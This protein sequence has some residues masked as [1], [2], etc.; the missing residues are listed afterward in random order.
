MNN[1]L[2]T[3]TLASGEPVMVKITVLGFP[4]FPTPGEMDVSRPPTM[5][6]YI[7]ILGNLHN[8]KFNIY[9]E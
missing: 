1:E 7:E 6:E 2:I 4:E 3:M 8:L 9:H 5:A